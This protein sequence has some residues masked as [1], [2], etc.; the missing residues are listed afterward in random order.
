MKDEELDPKEIPEIVPDKVRS[1]FDY[2]AFVGIAI[3][4]ISFHVGIN[5]FITGDDADTA[6]SIFSMFVPLTL[7]IIGFSVVKK[8]KG[9][10]VFGRAY[11]ALSFGYL[12]IF[13]AEVTY[14]V[15][16]I[17][18]NIEPYPSIAD[19]FFF[20]L[21]PLLLTY[22]FMNIKFFAPKLGTKSKIWIIL[23][24]ILVLI[25]YSILSTTAGEISIF[26]FDFYYGIVFVYFATLTLAVAV[27]GASIFKQG[28]IGKAWLIL[29]IG[30]LLNNIGDLWY[31]NLELFGEYD[32]VH[33]VNMFWY[34][35]YLVV[36]YALIKHKKTL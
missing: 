11:L 25:G 26:E 6:V 27:V 24:P 14:A 16:D 22:L 5:Y 28:A 33:P 3:L 4:V 30:I 35:G 12:S 8:Y 2:K 29:V 15:Y 19:V 7:S 9:T 17:V 23:M 21:Y 36:I 20:M 10:Q 13:F 34:A 1:S 32:L 31:Y 18:Y